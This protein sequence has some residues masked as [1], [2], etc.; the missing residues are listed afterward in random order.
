MNDN[1]TL[2]AYKFPDGE[3]KNK[4]TLPLRN[5]KDWRFHYNPE[6]DPDTRL[7]WKHSTF[8]RQTGK[9]FFDDEIKVEHCLTLMGGVQWG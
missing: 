1:Y 5:I 7:L 3:I 4:Y 9:G 6:M 8:A 2:H